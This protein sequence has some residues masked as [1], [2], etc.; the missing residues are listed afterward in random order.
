V[1]TFI[2]TYDL[3]GQPFTTNVVQINIRIS[4]SDLD[5]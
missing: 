5:F 3:R 1:H 4:K 2:D